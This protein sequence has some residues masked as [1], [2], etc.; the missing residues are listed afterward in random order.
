MFVFGRPRKAASAER[1]V[2]EGEPLK[3]HL[4]LVD[5]LK[6]QQDKIYADYKVLALA[7]N[8]RDKTAV[9]SFLVAFKKTWH[10]YLKEKNIK[11]YGYLKHNARLN[12]QQTM[13]VNGARAGSN[14]LTCKLNRFLSAYL[15]DEKLDLCNTSFES[16]EYSLRELGE[17]LIASMRME[18]ARLF[19]IYEGCTSL[20]SPAV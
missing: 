18:R 9:E 16:L 14:Q 2:R 10:R 4:N 6:E 7:V 1:E 17:E 11:L 8:A 3:Y 15:I 13:D 20:Q 12:A 19:P 5:D